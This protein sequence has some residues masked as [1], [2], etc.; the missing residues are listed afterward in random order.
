MI[1]SFSTQQCLYKA[2][3]KILIFAT[4]PKNILALFTGAPQYVYEM[5][6]SKEYSLA[7]TLIWSKTDFTLAEFVKQYELPQVVLVE[8]GYCG[9]DERTTF[10]SDQILTLHTVRTNSKIMCV[11]PPGNAVLVPSSCRLKAEVIPMEC[12]DRIVNAH[13]I[14]TIYKKVKYIR[15][16]EIGSTRNNNMSE[17]FKVG[18]ILQIKKV[19]M[20]NSVLRCKNIKTEENIMISTDSTTAFVPLADPNTHTLA[21]IQKSFG[22]PAKMR[23]TDKSAELRTR[24][25][26]GQRQPTMML[27]NLDQITA[28]EEIQDKDV[29]VTTV[30]SDPKETVRIFNFFGNPTF[31]HQGPVVSDLYT[32][33]FSCAE[34]HSNVYMIPRSRDEIRGGIILMY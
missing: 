19:D 3:L 17:T 21:E 30:C 32:S 26:P 1:Q 16:F 29:I 11:V 8:V 9:I 14:S 18:D 4:L 15:V 31:T 6:A 25:A 10:S 33:L 34:P 12:N 24:S 23:F 28:V 13:L 20:T 27:S 7:K 5:S 22:L 2:T